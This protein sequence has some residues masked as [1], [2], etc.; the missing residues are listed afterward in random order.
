MC[1]LFK[2]TAKLG[3]HGREAM[4]RIAL[5][6]TDGRTFAAARTISEQGH[7]GIIVR[8]TPGMKPWAEVMGYDID[9][10]TTNGNDSMNYANALIEALRTK[11]IDGV[12]L[13][14]E[15]LQFEGVT[16]LIIEAGY[17][18]KVVGLTSRT[19]MLIEGDKIACKHFCGEY[20]IPVCNSWSKVN[21]KDFPQV[22]ELCLQYIA[23]FGGV[24]L[25]YPYSAGGKGARVILNPWQ[26]KPVYDQL[27]KDYVSDY[28]KMFPSTAWPLL[29]ESWMAAI[30]I[31]C[32]IFVDIFGHYQVLPTS[33]DYPE[34]FPGPPGPHN[35]N[36]GGM[37]GL[38]PHPFENEEV[39]ELVREFIAKPIIE[40]LKQK[41]MCRACILYPQGMLY[42]DGHGRPIV[43]RLC[44][45]NAR[46]P[47]PEF[48]PGCRLKTCR[49]TRK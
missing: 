5:A 33:M 13:M 6:G 30:E 20:D 31:S 29:V 35:P 43:I 26:I 12:F 46:P 27:M 19:A 14:P 25:K 40:G 3:K 42:L 16:D 17:A 49:M 7:K 10:I 24:V 8:G 21:A 45:I 39:M 15:A 11:K 28:Q 38:S 18:S 37:A 22:R 44:E 36:T 4:K 9:F 48:Q 34:R 41:G 1:A 23:K 32:V 2:P 47:E